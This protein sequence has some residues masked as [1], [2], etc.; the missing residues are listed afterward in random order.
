MVGLELAQGVIGWLIGNEMWLIKHN[1]WSICVIFSPDRQTGIVMYHE[2]SRF[3]LNLIVVEIRVS[4]LTAVPSIGEIDV[5]YRRAFPFGSG[6]I[7]WVLTEQIPPHQYLLQ[8][9][10]AHHF[11]IGSRSV[12]TLTASCDSRDSTGHSNALCEHLPATHAV[13]NAG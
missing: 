8:I 11:R 3:E 10:L 12:V 6:G 13:E 1:Q 7:V 5:L 4:S 9:V 2:G